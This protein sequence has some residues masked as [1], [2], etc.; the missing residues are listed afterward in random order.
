M[1]TAS[2]EARPHPGR[3]SAA[4][5][6]GS[7]MPAD[8]LAPRDPVR[9]RRVDQRRVDPAHAVDR[10]QQDREDAEEGDERDLLAVADRVQQHDRDRQQRRRRHRP[11]VLDVRHRRAAASTRERPI[12]MPSATPTTTAIPKPRTIRSR[13]GTTCVA[14]LREEPHV[15]ELDEDRREP[16]EVRRCRRARSRA[17][18]RRGSASGTAISAPICEP[19]V[20]AAAHTASTR[21][22]G[23]QRSDAPLERRHQR[24]GSASPR[25]P[26]ASASA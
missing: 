19:A 24:G 25:K 6:P 9:A 7:T 20:G 4:A 3:R 8:P 14:E 1:I 26:V 17:A 11:P 2:A 13:L 15:L 18:R 10:V 22:D 16:R 5:P 23:C 21:C 12:G